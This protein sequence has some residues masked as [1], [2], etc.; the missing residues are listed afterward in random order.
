M[1]IKLRPR[2]SSPKIIIK[3]ELFTNVTIRKR[4]E[5]MGF[6]DNTVPKEDAEISIIKTRVKL[7]CIVIH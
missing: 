3:N 6:K 1:I 5:C 4:T 2:K 7:L